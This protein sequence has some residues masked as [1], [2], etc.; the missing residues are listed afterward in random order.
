MKNEVS[1]THLHPSSAKRVLAVITAAVIFLTISILPCPANTFGGLSIGVLGGSLSVNAESEAAKDIWRTELGVSVTT[2]GVGGAGFSS[3]QGHTL[4]RQAQEAGVHDLYVLWASTNDYMNG[5]PCGNLTDCTRAGEDRPESQ[6][7]GINRCISILR[8]KNPDCT[9]VLFTSLPFFGRQDGWDIT[10]PAEGAAAANPSYPTL[11][12]GKRKAKAQ[13]MATPLNFAGFIEA[14]KACAKA[15]GVAVLDQFL[16]CGFDLESVPAY[17]LGDRLHMTRAGYRHVAPMQ[18][19]F[20]RQ[21]LQNHLAQHPKTIVEGTPRIIAHRGWWQTEGSAQNSV[22]A[23]E[24]AASLGVWG[25]EFDVWMTSDSVLVVHHDAKTSTGLTI[26]SEPYHRLQDIRLAN[27]ECIPTLREV[28]ECFRRTNPE[29]KLVFEVKPHNTPEQDREAARR[30]V[31]M[32]KE[33]G[34]LERTEFI[35]FSKVAGETLIALAPKTPVYHLAGDLTPA[36]LKSRGYAGLDYSL[37]VMKKHPEWA[38]EAH[39]LGLGVNVWTVD[40]LEEMKRLY[41][42]LHADFITTNIPDKG[43]R[44]FPKE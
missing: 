44:L 2:Y 26:Q 1:M 6:C 20:L 3:E 27:G 42:D 36:E 33:K 12:K 43:L 30:C 5:R 10:A 35:T 25:C 4:Q 23:C 32:M 18:V 38:A 41:T 24:L 8:E 16:L 37:S 15:A 11:V 21:Q 17:Y 7:G 9:I 29:M 19:E 39:E 40:D 28:S 22:R 14:Q 31:E 34:L 13:A